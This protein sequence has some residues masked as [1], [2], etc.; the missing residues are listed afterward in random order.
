MGR[1]DDLWIVGGVVILGAM[2]T[3]SRDSIAWGSGWHWPVPDLIMKDGQRYTAQIS[4]EFKPDRHR[5]VD[6]MFR[7]KSLSD[8]PDF[9]AGVVD[10]GGAKA[11]ALWFAPQGIPIL[12]AKDGKVWSADKITTGWRVVLDH[13]KPWATAY[14]HLATILDLPKGKVVK[15]GD[16][17]GTM[18]HGPPDPEK[19]RHLHFE[20]WFNGGDSRASQDPAVIMAQW[21]RSSW[22]L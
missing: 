5:G 10:G 15:A 22:T 7:R 3:K 18:G 2:L 21:G 20:P 11:N 9:P 16:P 8:R 4:Q 1:N 19:L 17:I 12:A 13:G 14:H 6:V